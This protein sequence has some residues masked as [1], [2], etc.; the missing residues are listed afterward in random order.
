MK[1]PPN[2]EF[3]GVDFSCVQQPGNQVQ[4]DPMSFCPIPT[5]KSNLSPSVPRKSLGNR[6]PDAQVKGLEASSGL[7][8]PASPVRD[9]TSTPGY[10]PEGKWVLH[11]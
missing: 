10:E 4:S 1:T 2:D 9:R 5:A 7:T 3:G 6:L 8:T 11:A